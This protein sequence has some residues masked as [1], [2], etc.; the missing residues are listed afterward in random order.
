MVERNVKLDI[1]KKKVIVLIFFLF[2]LFNWNPGLSQGIQRLPLKSMSWTHR[3]I[4]TCKYVIMYDFV[5]HEDMEKKNK[6]YDIKKVEV[7]RT[8]TRY[9]S[10]IGEQMDSLGCI[11]STGYYWMDKIGAKNQPTLEDVYFNYPNKGMMFFTSYL[12]SYEYCYKESFPI[13]N[14]KSEEKMDTVILGYKCYKATTDFYGRHYTAWFAPDIPLQ[15]G[16]YKFCGL[17]G[18]IMKVEDSE[19]YFS[20]TVFSI[21]QPKYKPMYFE[22]GNTIVETDRKGYLKILNMQWKDIG[23]FYQSQGKKIYM[24]GVGYIEPGQV[25]LPQIP[26]IEKE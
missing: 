23:L 16:P 9:H 5:F 19:K 20:W 18:L 17:P 1:M 10:Y 13:I 2:L 4:D 14:W 6:S 15:V 7:G 3:L 21:I 8:Y 11:N 24:G 25:S 26:E 22:Q 12:L